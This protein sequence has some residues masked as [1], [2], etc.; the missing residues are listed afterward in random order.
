MLGTLRRAEIGKFKWDLVFY[1]RKCR[2]L[3]LSVLEQ[4]GRVRDQAIGAF[5]RFVVR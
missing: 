4:I 1:D 3:Q 2:A 5:F